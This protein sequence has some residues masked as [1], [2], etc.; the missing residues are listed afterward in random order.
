MARRA[1][2]SSHHTTRRG[3]G[4]ARDRHLQQ[5]NIVKCTV[6]ILWVYGDTVHLTDTCSSERPESCAHRIQYTF[7]RHR[8]VMLG[9]FVHAE[10]ICS[11]TCNGIIMQAVHPLRNVGG[12][13][14]GTTPNV[15]YIYCIC[16]AILYIC[17]QAPTT[18]CRRQ[19]SSLGVSTSPPM[20]R[21]TSSSALPSN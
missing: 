9:L 13:C 4:E 11:T 3:D 5:T 20:R 19:V 7:G 21:A 10:R 14:N 1:D 17:R 8:R 16:M 2:Q 15:Q 12:R 6:H 18:Q